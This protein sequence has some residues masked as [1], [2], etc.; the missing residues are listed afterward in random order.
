MVSYALPL[1]PGPF[2]IIFRWNINRA[3]NNNPLYWTTRGACITAARRLCQRDREI[4]VSRLAG[5]IRS[6]AIPSKI[7]AAR[8][9]NIRIH[10]DQSIAVAPLAIKSASGRASSQRANRV[11]FTSNCGDCGLPR[12]AWSLYDNGR[13]HRVP[14][15]NTVERLRYHGALVMV[16]RIKVPYIHPNTP[17]HLLNQLSTQDSE[18][19][20]RSLRV[21]WTDFGIPNAR[22]KQS[23]CL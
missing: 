19:S 6:R 2:S 4:R 8:R 1:T 13:L 23:L 9:V 3:V 7:F 21:H 5:C 14:S 17:N 10:V 18:L 15:S 16:S 12:R 20:Q 11:K 22:V